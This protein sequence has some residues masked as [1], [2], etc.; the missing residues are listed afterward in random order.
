MAGNAA[1]RFEQPL[2]ALSIARF[3]D[4]TRRIKKSKKV[5]YLLTVKRR[6]GAFF[7]LHVAPHARRMVPHGADQ[8]VDARQGRLHKT[9]VG[10]QPSA[11]P[12]TAWQCA[13]PFFWN[14]WK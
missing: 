1:F 6:V 7:G 10:R 11:T 5:R 4:I 14:S 8:F 3:I 12:L 9:Q 13:Q 2:T